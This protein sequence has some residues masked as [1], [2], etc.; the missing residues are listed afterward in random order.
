[1]NKRIRKIIDYLIK[2]NGVSNLNDLSNFMKVNK[3]TIRYDIKKI[4]EI[5]YNNNLPEIKFSKKKILLKDY[6]TLEN[7]KI[8]LLNYE[9]DYRN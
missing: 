9:N 1:M 6:I 5:F 7:I 3:R 2:N 4:N 8:N